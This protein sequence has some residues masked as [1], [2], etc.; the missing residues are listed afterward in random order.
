MERVVFADSQKQFFAEAGLKSFDGL[1]EHS[2]AGPI[3]KN[4]KNKNKKRNV[5]TL[6]LQTGSTCKEFFIKRFYHPH[7]KDIITSWWNFKRQISQAEIEWHN[8]RLLLEHGFGTYQPVCFGEKTKLGLE[9]KS[10]IIT[11]KLKTQPMPEFV[12]ENW[13]QM[14]RQKKE[15]IICSLAKLIRKIHDTRIS[16]PDL[17]IWHIFIKEN[18]DTADCSFQIIDL[19]RMMHNV[20]SKNHQIKNLARLDYSLLDKYFDENLRRLLIQVYAGN[21][22]PGGADKLFAK[23]KKHSA[24]LLTKR[25]QKQY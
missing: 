2:A 24:K 1:F 25:T 15:K 8:A 11:E 9:R 20:T 18:E 6:T 13:Q 22:W 16:L 3:N 21:D 19:H 4:K 10:F 7:Y 23:I 5:S 17:Y 12:A 14:T